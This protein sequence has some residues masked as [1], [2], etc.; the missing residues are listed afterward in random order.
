M[1]YRRVFDVVWS[2]RRNLIMMASQIDRTGNQNISA[3]GPWAQPKR[4]QVT[5]SAP[6]QFVRWYKSTVLQI[7]VPFFF[8]LFLYGLQ[9]GATANDSS[10]IPYPTAY[11]HS[12]VPACTVRSAVRRARRS[13]DLTGQ[14]PGVRPPCRGR[15]VV[16][17]GYAPRQRAPVHHD[18]VF[19]RE[20]HHHHRDHVD[21][22]CQ[23][24][25]AHGHQLCPGASAH[26]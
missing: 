21:L 26:W 24:Q 13:G 3:I 9:K 12:G 6:Q 25:R 22:Y 10:N 15:V 18:H 23:Q 20:R 14:Q 1:P 8:I 19:A 4:V 11:P 16:P 2:G 7:I 17:A 5:R